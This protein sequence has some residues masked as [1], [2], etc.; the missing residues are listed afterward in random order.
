MPLY[1]YKCSS[2]GTILDE[3]RCLERR[4]ERTECPNGCSTD[5]TRQFAVPRLDMG[6]DGTTSR[7]IGKNNPNGPDQRWARDNVDWDAQGL[8]DY[9]W[10]D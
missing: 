1:E 9:G 2:C 7:T 5:M 3:M 8:P 4:D 10:G 6:K